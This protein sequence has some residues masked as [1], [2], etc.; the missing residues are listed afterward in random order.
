MS[1][2]LP[3]IK[4]S[5]SD[6]SSQSLSVLSTEITSS[7]TEASA[8]TLLASSVP[9]SMTSSELNTVVSTESLT[10]SVFA[11]KTVS[12]TLFNIASDSERTLMLSS[13]SQSQSISS[14]IPTMSIATMDTTEIS[15]TSISLF[16]TPMSTSM[17][18]S[19]VTVPLKLCRAPSF[20]NGHFTGS[21]EVNEVVTFT[22]NEGYRLVGNGSATCLEN[23]TWTELPQCIKECGNLTAPRNGSVK[24]ECTNEGCVAQYAC[25]TGYEL[26][27][28]ASRTCTSIGWSPGEPTCNPTG[29]IHG[30]NVT[31]QLQSGPPDD[32]IGRVQYQQDVYDQL[33]KYYKEN[34]GDYFRQIV[35]VSISPDGIVDYSIFYDN[36]DTA[37]S[38]FSKSQS[39]FFKGVPLTILNETIPVIKITLAGTTYE[40]NATID[41]AELMCDM[42]KH[43]RGNCSAD[44]TCSTDLGRPVCEPARTK[45]NFWWIALLGAGIPLLVLGAIL[46]IFCCCWLCPCCRRRR[47]REEE[48]EPEWLPYYGLPR[49]V[50]IG[51]RITHVPWGAP[52]YGTYQDISEGPEPASF[53]VEPDPDQDDPSFRLPRLVLQPS[54]YPPRVTSLTTSIDDGDSEPPFRY[55]DNLFRS[56]ADTIEDADSDITLHRARFGAVLTYLDTGFPTGRIPLRFNTTRRS[57]PSYGSNISYNR[58]ID[59]A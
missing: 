21:T 42:Y 16:S 27:G 2:T 1:S 40:V 29:E 33:T 50:G 38:V 9:S 52:T 25:A 48:P 44:D 4:M 5:T 7:I 6:S 37:H 45:D 49:Y 3:S 13:V 58:D 30:T 47:K 19:S 32:S 53:V 26:S 56:P 10:P 43:L 34:I 17:M 11:S 41:Q 31:I 51:R 22:C 20:D 23:R 15:H 18:S 59:E 14:L 36:L 39:A 24:Y 55:P 46:G 8:Q 57:A 12:S 28:Q 35:I 54:H